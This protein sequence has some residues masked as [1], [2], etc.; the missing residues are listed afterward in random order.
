MPRV[1]T[2]DTPVTLRRV[3][4]EPSDRDEVVPYLNEIDICR[5]LPI[6]VGSPDTSKFWTDGS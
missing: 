2:I 4:V 6:L 3:T 5:L 1:I